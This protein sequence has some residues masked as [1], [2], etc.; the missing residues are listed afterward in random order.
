MKNEKKVTEMKK[1]QI[2]IGNGGKNVTVV[3]M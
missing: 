1:T 3:E 2:F